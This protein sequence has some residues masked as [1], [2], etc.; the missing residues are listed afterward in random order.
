MQTLKSLLDKIRWDPKENPQGYALHYLDRFKPGLQEL[1][2]ER[3]E[4]EEDGFL[5]TT[6]DAKEVHIPLH[7]VRKVTKHGETA[8]ERPQQ[9]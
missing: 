7:R 8:W 2:L 6:I 9:R 4:K 1:P 5:A 3:V